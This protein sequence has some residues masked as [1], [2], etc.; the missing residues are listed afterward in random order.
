MA[1]KRYR[2]ALR[3][4]RVCG[5]HPKAAWLYFKDEDER[6][7][8]EELAQINSNTMSLSEIDFRMRLAWRNAW[9]RSWSN[10]LYWHTGLLRLNLRCPRS[11]GKVRAKDL[12]VLRVN[13]Q[14]D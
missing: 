9:G 10:Y 13:G 3:R 8:R 1:S 7:Y 2:K 5:L 12:I 4:K 6:M 11:H 14:E